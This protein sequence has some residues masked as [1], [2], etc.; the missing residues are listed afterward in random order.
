MTLSVAH[1]ERLRRLAENECWLFADDNLADYQQIEQ[2][3]GET[4]RLLTAAELQTAICRTNGEFL[5]WVD[6]VLAELPPDYWIAAS[7][8]KDVVCT[9]V[10]LH[11]ACLRVATDA[12]S[13]GHNV[14][15]ITRSAA[16]A[17]QVVV[18]NGTLCSNTAIWWQDTF[19][20]RVMAWA[21]WMVRPWQ[22]FLRTLLAKL[23]FGPN[24]LSNLQNLQVLVDTFFFPG[25]LAPDGGYKD[26]F[27]PGLIDWYETHG[28]RVASM[29]YTGHVPLREMFSAY[30]RMR[31][32]KTRFVLGECFLGIMDCLRGAW[33]SAQLY[34]CPPT[35][36]TT[37]FYGVRC[38]QI[39]LYWWQISAL[40]T[41][42]YQIWLRAPRNMLRQGLIPDLVVDW[43]ENQP[44]DKAVCLGFQKHCQ[45]TRVIAGRQ[46]LPAPGIVNF[47]STAG[48]VRAGAAPSLNWVCGKR[49][50]AMFAIYDPSGVSCIV[51]ALRYS[52]LF[53]FSV[54]SREGNKLVVFLTSLPEESMGIL[55][56]VFAADQSARSRFESVLVKIHQ[57]VDARFRNRAENRWPSMRGRGVTWDQRP[58]SALLDEAALVVTGASSVALEAVCRG[59]PVI[60][61]GRPAGISFNVLEGID[62]QLWRIA[63]D[64]RE[65]QQLAREWLPHVPDLATR[66]EAGRRIRDEHFEMVTSENMQAFDPRRIDK[67]TLKEGAIQS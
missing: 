42:S 44:L 56:C 62:Q 38:E 48:E 24:D 58:A 34:R 17:K 12:I 4:R 28:F 45:H 40:Q 6:D 36:S 9:P 43:Y 33:R 64:S 52:Y 54:P 29:P 11:M 32:S 50:A 22:I 8:F 3:Y 15:L 23:Q 66:R 60:V 25:D 26:R 49:T 2:A 16:L 37:P 59:V 41:V 31:R 19:K 67:I 20:Q 61:S 51:P 55:E 14:I 1:P 30:K 10:L 35:F 18:L 63:Y 13:A 5:R 7:Y 47:F 57:S 39:A 65:F 27:S 21:H 46:F 53:D